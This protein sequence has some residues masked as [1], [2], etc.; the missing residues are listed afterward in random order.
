MK[1]ISGIALLT[2]GALATCTGAFAQQLKANIPFEFTVGNTT[3]PAGEYS[4]WSPVHDLIELRNANNQSIAIVTGNQS[5]EEL[6]SKSGGQL[7]FAKYGDQYFL[8]H[9]HCPSV[10]ALNLDI[11]T[12]KAE[13]RARA[14]SLEAKNPSDGQKT[15]VAMR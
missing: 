12:G 13:K 7:V 8:D 9:V 10:I 15:L 4:V 11:A 14:R 6:K 5:Y 3:M 2:L 1:R